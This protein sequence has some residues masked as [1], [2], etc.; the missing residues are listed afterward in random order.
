MVALGFEPRKSE[1]LA[2]L[3]LPALAWLAPPAGCRLVPVAVL[4]G[5]SWLAPTPFDCPKSL[6]LLGCPKL[7]ESAELAACKSAALAV[8]PKP[9][10]AIISTLAA[11]IS[12][13]PN[14]FISYIISVMADS[15]F[16]K[17]VR[18]EIP[19]YKIYEDEKTLAF[20]DIHPITSGH[21]LVIPKRQVEFVWDLEPEDYQALMASVQKVA[22]HLREATG[23]PIV[24][25]QIIGV[26][27]PH[28]HVHLIPFSDVADFHHLA[29]QS[30]EPDHDK[31]AA[32]AR[33]LAMG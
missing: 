30:A 4:A 23:Q 1:M 28:A 21:T 16:T 5:P 9:L 10:T 13:T 19:C 33:Q 12:P 17:I 31:L 7:L 25:T 15:I 29:D 22:R 11:T 20:L 14:F 6:L 32:L 24:G 3:R 26:D 27:V 8:V 2:E 18:G